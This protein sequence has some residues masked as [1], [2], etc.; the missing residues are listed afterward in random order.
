VRL[1][2][3]DVDGTLVDAGGAGRESLC[4]AFE[5]IFGLGEVGARAATV[6]FDG[7]T[8]SWIIAEIAD[9]AGVAPGRLEER[10]GDLER[11]YLAILEEALAGGRRARALPGVSALLEALTAAG[12]AV[13]LVTGNIRKGAQVKLAAAGVARYF[14]EGAFGD[15]SPDRV[16]LARLARERFEKRAGVRLDPSSVVLIGDSRQDVRAA[17]ANGYRSLAVATGWT[18]RGDLLAEG[19]DRLAED[20]AAT[21][22]ILTWIREAA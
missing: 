9:R 13:G 16:E 17:R 15:D 10:R 5:R 4:R 2:L 8:D 3:F 19:P 7:R 20:L 14:E 1:V 18:G 12:L 21:E 6:P 11:T 22:E